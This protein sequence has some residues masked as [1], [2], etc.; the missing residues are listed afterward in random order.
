MLAPRELGV[1]VDFDR[2]HRDDSLNAGVFPSRCE[3]K[4][5]SIDSKSTSA[6]GGQ[7]K[8]VLPLV[9]LEASLSSNGPKEDNGVQP[10]KTNNRTQHAKSSPKCKKNTKI[11]LGQLLPPVLNRQKLLCFCTCWS[12]CACVR[13]CCGACVQ[14]CGCMHACACVS[15]CAHCS[16]SVGIGFIIVENMA[17]MM[18]TLGA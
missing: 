18:I 4:P 2:F 12:V 17:Q 16:L 1:A 3:Q 15:M 13:V 8:V 14:I 9:Q 5:E 11:L 6:G 10:K 7:G